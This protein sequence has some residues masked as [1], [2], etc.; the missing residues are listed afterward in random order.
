MIIKKERIT[1]LNNN[2]ISSGSYVLYWM[3]SSQREHY[4]H[5]LEYSILQAN[6]LDL[7]LLVYFGL[8]G[9]FPE[10]N[11]RHYYFMLEGLKEL[12]SSLKDRGI[13]ILIL[14]ESPEIGAANLGLNASLIIVDGGY[15]KI[16][17]N[18]RKY[19][20]ENVK[21]P[22]IQ[23]ESNVVVP[24]ETAS[25]KE[26]YSA[27]TLRRKLNK[28]LDE[29]LVPLKSKQLEKGSYEIGIPSLNIKDI[30]KVIKDLKVD[31]TV[32]EAVF[33]KGGTNSALKNLN[34]FLKKKIDNFPQLR[35][36]PTQDYLSHLS[37]Y[38]HFGQISPLYIALEAIKTD[39]PGVESFLEELI[40]RRE[41]SMNYI[42][43]NP[44]YDSLDGLPEWPRKTLREHENDLREYIYTL[45]ELEYAQ[46]HDPYWNAAQKEMLVRGKMHGYMRMY[47]GKKI[48]E[49]TETPE[50]AFKIALYLNNKYEIDG[51]DP[52]GYTGVAWCFGKHDR[53]WKERKIFGKVRYMN[54]NGL[55]RKFKIDKYV[56]EID[57]IE[58]LEG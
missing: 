46:T 25:V 37:P 35:N 26:E 42:Y 55:K 8:T 20:S 19:V 47:W 57:E 11:R 54:A 58:K 43:Y 9:D 52:N 3:Q 39:S 18:W 5:A 33:Y 7:P 22:L 53:A 24:V 6:R 15:L 32:R 16:E 13:N 21:C 1:K 40:V 38:L 2:K 28:I 27:A 17:R 29:F 23:V 4:N 14:N 49:W 41:L 12:E 10:A 34:L 56:E 51:R 31:E 50:K 36:D 45:E 30:D 48:L 44:N